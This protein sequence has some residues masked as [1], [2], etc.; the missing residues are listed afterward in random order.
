MH[1]K[2]MDINE[3][4]I[5]K[6]FLKKWVLKMMTRFIWLRTGT[7]DRSFKHDNET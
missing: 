6:R 7:I 3:R 4:I 5:L 2:D 1:L